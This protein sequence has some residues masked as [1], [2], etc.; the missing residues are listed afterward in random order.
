MAREVTQ[1]PRVPLDLLTDL[2]ERLHRDTPQATHK[3]PQDNLHTMDLK[4]P[5]GWGNVLWVR[6]QCLRW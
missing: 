5:P 6:A 4:A 1:D 2:M 3:A